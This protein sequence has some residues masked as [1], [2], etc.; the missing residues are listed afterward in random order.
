[1][2]RNGF[3]E[4]GDSLT[5][6]NNVTHIY[7]LLNQQLA[8]HNEFGKWN[9]DY[10]AS[11]GMTSSDEPDRRQ[12]MFE[13]K[14]DG[15][16][17]FFRLNQQETMRYFGELDE[18]EIAT[19]VKATWNFGKRDSKLRFG[20][21][22]KNKNRNYNATRFYYNVN[23]I[24]DAISSLDDINNYINQENVATG[25]IVVDRNRQPKDRYD[26][27]SRVIAGFLSVDWNIRKKISIQPGL[28]LET[29]RQNVDYCTEKKQKKTSSLEGTELFP[30][31]NFKYTFLKSHSIRFSASRTITRPSF[32]EM[33]P[34]L[35]Q[36]SYGSIQIRGNE[37][38]DNGYNYNF[39]LRYEHI[40]NKNNLLS[41]TPYIK[42]LDKPIERVQ[43]LAGGSAVHSFRNAD[44]GLAMGIELEARYQIIDCLKASA[45]AS[46][47]FT[48]VKLPEGGGAYTNSQ[49]ALQ[50]ASP[51]LV[52]ADI[53]YTKKIHK[54][55][56]ISLTALY[57]LQGPRIHAVGISGLGDVTQK[58]Q[59]TLN[60][61]IAYKINRH[62]G[63]SLKAE[64]LLNQ[65]IKFVQEV[66]QRN[67]DIT[68]EK[69]KE[70]I[71]FSLNA[72]CKF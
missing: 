55:S 49:R 31:V 32:I 68:V 23:G 44:M 38:L 46:F 60:A 63:L 35:Y 47:M 37:K 62:F 21:A 26:A 36:E 24:S 25:N 22:F 34:F 40:D 12:V 53:T 20:I 45:N 19:N 70:G 3:D 57:N 18:D 7:S 51:F 4:E 5:G 16:I 66:P 50:G 28:S 39:D 14:T 65:S 42:I 56:D 1:M 48:N 15:S 64:N 43:E 59:H 61:I 58:T 17:S 69:F 33:A 8:G 13:N 11:Y 54:N 29:S 72:N 67:K 10:G 2:V 27:E 6:S 71:A 52:N 9:L 30:A 41:A